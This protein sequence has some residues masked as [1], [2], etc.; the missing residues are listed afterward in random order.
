MII[1]SSV[2]IAAANK[3][4]EFNG[5]AKE[6]L[7]KAKEERACTTDHVLGEVVTYLNKKA[8]SEM[9][10]VEGARIMDS[11]GLV[12]FTEEDL[13]EALELLKKYK[14]LSLCDALSVVAANETRDKSICSFDSDFDFVKGVRRIF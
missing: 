8:G 11:F 6:L 14:K 2:F 5:R 7:L 12:F 4:D 13:R 1:D 9:A 3:R 10:C